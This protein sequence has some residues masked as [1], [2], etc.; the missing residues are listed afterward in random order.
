MK[1]FWKKFKA[2]LFTKSQFLTGMTIALIT[3]SALVYAFNQMALTIFQPNTPISSQEINDNF[4]YLN[5]RIKYLAGNQFA[6][7]T[8]YDSSPLVLS[9]GLTTDVV[10][11]EVLVDFSDTNEGQNLVDNGTFAVP[12][13][14]EYVIDFEMEGTSDTPNSGFYGI[15]FAERKPLGSGSFQS[16]ACC[17]Y[18]SVSV[19]NSLTSVNSTMR[20]SWM[21]TLISGDTIRFRAGAEPWGTGGNIEF[22]SIRVKGNQ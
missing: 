11:N 19:Y 21:G 1:N 7:K 9:S 15:V 18:P 22:L 3:T 5:E 2:G 20:Q 17:S 4:E 12:D 10:F 8:N 14:A 16:F 13:T 6:V